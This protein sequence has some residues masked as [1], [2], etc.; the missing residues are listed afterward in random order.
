MNTDFDLNELKKDHNTN[1]LAGMLEKL[2]REE[3]E[4]REMLDSDETLHEMAGKELKYIQE[5]KEVIEKQIQDILDKEKEAEEFPN[6]IVLEVRAGAGG[7]EASLFAWELAHMYEKFAEAQGFDWKV[8]Y[9]QK[10][11]VSGF[12]EASFEVKGKDVYRLMRREMGIHR[13]QRIPATEKNGRVH[14]STASVAILPIKKK[15]NFVI[16][17]ADLEMEYS[18]SGGKGGQNVNKVETAVRLIHKPTGLDV[19]STNERS[20]LANREKALMILTAKLQQLKEEEDAKKYSGERKDQIGTG[21][22]SEKIRTYNFPQDRVT[23]HRIKK[24]WHNLPKLME[25][26]IKDII[27]DLEAGVVGSDIED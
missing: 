3:A 24:S 21:D 8:N 9:E 25:G 7:D 10:S 4:V 15:I 11:D 23:D 6:E 27:D 5:Q 20:Q 19:R 13:V 12:K 18:R 14:T 2:L 17:P 16:N 22:R 1:Y 26:D